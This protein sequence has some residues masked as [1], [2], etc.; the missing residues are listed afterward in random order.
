MNFDEL[1]SDKRMKP[2]EKTTFLS[3]WLLNNRR[4]LSELMDYAMESKDPIKA[5]CVEAVEYASKQQPDIVDERSFDRIVDLLQHKA[6]RVKWESAKV[7]GNVAHLHQDN[8]S[9]AIGLLLT[10]TSYDGTVVRWSCAYALGEIV[11]LPKFQDKKFVEKLRS[12]MELEESNSIKK[13]YAS[14]FKKVVK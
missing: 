2:K 3:E 10:N 1:F 13:I 11:K 4:K 7:I 12:I 14:A 9:T 8:L 5:T 6:P